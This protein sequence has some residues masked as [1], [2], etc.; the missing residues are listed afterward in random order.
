MKQLQK[1]PGL[2]F[3]LLQKDQKAECLPP[4][5]TGMH[6]LSK[7][8][9]NKF[10]RESGFETTPEGKFE[11]LQGILDSEINRS[12]SAE[13]AVYPLASAIRSVYDIRK[14]TAERALNTRDSN[15]VEYG[16]R[17]ELETLLILFNRIE[18]KVL[19]AETKCA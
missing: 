14:N 11:F 4:E 6:L 10:V 1:N 5:I 17:K 8:L 7:F 16:I 12:F 15:H 13:D 19:E 18:P 2:K 3:F 9:L